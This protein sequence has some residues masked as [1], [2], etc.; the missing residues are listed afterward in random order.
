[1]LFNS[2]ATCWLV[3]F[4][5]FT[6]S[7]NYC[8]FSTHYLTKEWIE[9]IAVDTWL[10]LL[11]FACLL[12][13]LFVC[14]FEGEVAGQLVIDPCVLVGRHVRSWA[15]RGFLGVDWPRAESASRCHRLATIWSRMTFRRR[16]KKKSRFEEDAA[17]EVKANEC[18]VNFRTYSSTRGR[19]IESGATSSLIQ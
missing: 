10:W 11:F 15:R 12:A 8:Q 6:S 5:S 9:Q 14:L 4:S 13:C 19:S 1:M 17:Q 18:R 7:L 2:K 16:I 3:G